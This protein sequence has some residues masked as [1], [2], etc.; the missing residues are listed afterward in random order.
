MVSRSAPF[1]EVS[2]TSFCIVSFTSGEAVMHKPLLAL[3]FIVLVVS[4]ANAALAAP[5]AGDTYVY[6]IYNV[7]SN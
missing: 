4:S 1:S 6:R 2:D 5:V 7:Y 3:L